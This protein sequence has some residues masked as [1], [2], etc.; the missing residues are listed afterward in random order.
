MSKTVM[1]QHRSMGCRLP[2]S[3]VVLAML[4]FAQLVHADAAQDFG[5]SGTVGSYPIAMQMRVREQGEIVQ[6]HYSYAS[7]GTEIPLTVA[8]AA[9]AVTLTEPGGGVF[10]L[11]FVGSPGEPAHDMQHAI[12]LAGTWVKG[13]VTLPVKLQLEAAEAAG[14]NVPD[15]A[16]YPALTAP[17]SK[18]A[19]PD[20]GCTHIPDQ[21]VLDRCIQASFT[22]THAVNQCITQAVR[23][24]RE[25]QADQNRCVGNLIAYL[26]D[27]IQRMLRTGSATTGALDA[28]SYPAW[29]DAQVARCKKGSAF[30]PGG[31]GYGADI[32]YCMAGQMLGLVQRRLVPG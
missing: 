15:C 29:H 4:F 30:S 13:A 32:G 22:T 19:F 10:H 6:A 16:Y 2:I 1:P 21:T 8:T 20:A 31:S 12:G 24:C 25:D 14:A 27:S 5:M 9:D 23:P 18:P 17:G 7:K 11:H 3:L 26:D 28:R